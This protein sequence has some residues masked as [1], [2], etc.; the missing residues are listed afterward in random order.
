MLNSLLISFVITLLIRD[1]DDGDGSRMMKITKRNILFLK[2]LSQLFVASVKILGSFNEI[3]PH[4]WLKTLIYN[5]RIEL[6]N[7]Q[8]DSN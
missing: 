8:P 5:G 2:S 3:H 4:L 7:N 1:G 6:S